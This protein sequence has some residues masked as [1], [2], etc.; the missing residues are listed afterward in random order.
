MTEAGREIER[1]GEGED[2]R[3]GGRGRG[4]ERIVPCQY[5]EV[6]IILEDLFLLSPG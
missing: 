5:I 4:G 6:A 1:E 2:G 3:T